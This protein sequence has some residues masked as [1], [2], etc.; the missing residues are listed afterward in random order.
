MS[1]DYG[2]NNLSDFIAK[3]SDIPE[4]KRKSAISFSVQIKDFDK[5]FQK[6]LK[7]SVINSYAAQT[8]DG[9][10]SYIIRKLF[11]AYFTNPAQMQDSAVK[12]FFKLI[13]EDYDRSRIM[14]V[15]DGNEAVLIRV[16]ADYIAGMTDNFAYE[17]FDLLYGTRR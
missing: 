13:K 8:L 15:L 11:K 7:D 1:T 2:I 12:S 10:G 3:H 17:Q 14:D 6:L 5:G 16:I 9:K 4:D